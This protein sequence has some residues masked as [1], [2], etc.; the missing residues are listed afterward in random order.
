MTERFRAHAAARLRGDAAEAAQIASEFT[1]QERR[2]HLIF[3]QSL[4]AGVVVDALGDRPDPFDLARFAKRLH[5]E[6]FQRDACGEPTFLALRAEAMIRS[7]FG[8]EFLLFEIPYAEQPGYMWAVMAALCG[9]EPT[10]DQLAAHSATAAEYA[11]D[12]IDSATEGI[13]AT[14]AEPKADNS[15]DDDNDTEAEIDTGADA[16]RDTGADSES[17]TEGEAGK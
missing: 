8:E 1:E 5:D 9:P 11:R 14:F 3:V 17:D 2:L 10:D 16:V 15:S 7:L 13:I 6:H 12:G 4:F